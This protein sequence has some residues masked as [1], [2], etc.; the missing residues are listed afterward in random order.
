MNPTEHKPSRMR[1]ALVAAIGASIVTVAGVGAF[2]GLNA[3]ATATQNQSAGTLSLTTANNGAGFS[4]SVSNMAPG[5]VVNRYVNITNGGSLDAQGL[6]LKVSSTG[7]ASLI[8]NGTSP[9]TNKA[10]TVAVKSCSG[11]W[12]TSTGVCSGS[13]STEIAATPLSTFASAQSFANTTT[14]DSL[15]GLKL[16]IQVTLPDQNETTADGVAPANTVQNGSVALTYEFFEAQRTATTT[17][18]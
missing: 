1:L 6:S 4:Q 10:I 18:S 3:T 14:L 2:A 17:N 15:A 8:T 5:D 16:Q 12:N 13:T 11:T 9:A 7:T